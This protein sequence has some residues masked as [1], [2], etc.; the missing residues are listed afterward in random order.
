MIHLEAV[1]RLR[2]GPSGFDDTE[3]NSLKIFPN[4]R[5]SNRSGLIWYSSQRYEPPRSLII[6]PFNYFLPTSDP[7]LWPGSQISN[8]NPIGTSFV[9]HSLQIHE[10]ILKDAKPFCPNL[11][12]IQTH[13]SIHSMFPFF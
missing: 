9:D 13:C 1:R 10:N 5:E 11:N 2:H 7:L 4:L 12:C 6:T 3:I 8:L